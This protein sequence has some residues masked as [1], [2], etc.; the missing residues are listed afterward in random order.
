LVL[1][2][3]IGERNIRKNP[4]LILGITFLISIGSIIFADVLFPK[5][6]SVLS[7]AFITIGL[8]P[9]IHNILSKE[10][11]D[12]ALQRKC[13]ATFFARHFNVIMIY[14]WIFVGVILAFAMVYVVVPNDMKQDLF[15]EQINSFC[16]ITGSENCEN[17]VP[18]SIVGKASAIAFNSCQNPATK[19]VAACS[20]YIFQN[21]GGVLVFIIILSLLYGA[22]AIFIIAWNA[23]ILGL[24][25]GEMILAAQH[26]KWIG[27][28]QG[29]LIGHGP[30]ELLGYVFGALAGAILSAMVSRGQFLK[31]EFTTI[32]RDVS[33]LILLAIFSVLYGAVVE[34]VGLMQYTELY[35]VL[36]FV[37][38]LGLIALVVFY[39]RKAISRKNIC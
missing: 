35:F 6:S 1:E 37:Y 22:G 13:S 11:Y 34:A 19:N 15:A 12:E 29:M 28:L 32:F 26:L 24:F 10:E 5:H 8:V 14:I 33:F 17:G 25:F 18:Y 39:G 3:L 31:H 9:L 2:S 7:V 30:P 36:G 20:L 16:V 27:F 23:S 21:N 38:V 4:V